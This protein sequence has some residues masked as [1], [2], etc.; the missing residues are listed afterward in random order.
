MKLIASA[1]DATWKGHPVRV[2]RNELTHGFSVEVAGKVAV[3][4]TITLTGGG[5]WEGDVEVD[6]HKSHVVIELL[7]NS[8]CDL[9]VDGEKLVVTVLP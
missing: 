7:G 3:A 4:R 8:E 6:G 2:A 1:W 9:W 5:H